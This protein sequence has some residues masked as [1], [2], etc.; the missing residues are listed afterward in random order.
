MT[1]PEEHP[2]ET[3]DELLAKL[4][5]I[6]SFVGALFVIFGVIVTIIGFTASDAEIAK[7]TGV[8]LA[9][10]LGLI[11]LVMGVFFL[12]WLVLKPPEILHGHE[13]SEDDL[14]EQM[15]HH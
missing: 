1:S 14:P 12:A 6:R 7:A 2:G 5:D 3:G 15:R 4:L 8:N 11:M 13:A 9:L 10:W